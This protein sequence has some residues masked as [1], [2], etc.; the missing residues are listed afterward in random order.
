MKKKYK[1]ICIIIIIFLSFVVD[2]NTIK[3]LNECNIGD[4]TNSKGYGTVTQLYTEAQAGQSATIYFDN[5]SQDWDVLDDRAREFSIYFSAPKKYN[6]EAGKIKTFSMIFHDLDGKAVCELNNNNWGPEAVGQQ[7]AIFRFNIINGDLLKI[8]ASG[9]YETAD[10][11]TKEFKEKE[12]QISKKTG[13]S[14]SVSNT[15]TTK[16]TSAG[17]TTTTATKRTVQDATPEYVVPSSSYA[18]GT[19]APDLVGDSQKI[20][21]DSGDG[22]ITISEFI[23]KYW[24]WIMILAPV[25]L[26]LLISIDFVKAVMSSDTEMLKKSSSAA[27]KRTIAVVAL[28]ML[29]VILNLVLGWFG[30]EIC[31]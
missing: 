18:K 13:N 4:G 9:T 3:G 10:G 28:L 5:N 15:T 25:S 16:K 17:E 30:I 19:K 26:M 21:C 6:G 23:N 22:D 20:G 29:P 24:S 1:F 11:E 2:I 12:F 14:E 7:Y 27:L 31:I 8:T